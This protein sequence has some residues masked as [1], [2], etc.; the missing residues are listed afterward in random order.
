MFWEPVVDDD[1]PPRFYDPL[2]SG[3]YKGRTTDKELVYDK[4]DAYNETVGWDARGVPTKDTLDKLGLN[5][6]E[7]SMKKL[8]K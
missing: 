3:P 2:P 7:S 6:L 8:R 1:N 5:D 4:R